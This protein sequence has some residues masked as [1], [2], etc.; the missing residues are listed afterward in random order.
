MIVAIQKT[1]WQGSK[2]FDTGFVIHKRVKD[3][4]LNFESAN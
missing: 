4:M 2:I 3:H 1:R